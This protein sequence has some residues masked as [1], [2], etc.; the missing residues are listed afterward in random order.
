MPNNVQSHEPCAHVTSS[1]SGEHSTRLQHGVT[2][3]RR[4]CTQRNAVNCSLHPAIPSTAHPTLLP[5]PLQPCLYHAAALLRLAGNF[6]SLANS[7]HLCSG[8]LRGPLSFLQ[9]TASAPR[10][11]S[12]T[13]PHPHHVLSVLA[14]RTPTLLPLLCVHPSLSSITTS[15]W[16]AAL[17]LCQ[18]HHISPAFGCGSCRTPYCSGAARSR[19]D[20]R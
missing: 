10:L 6:A 2:T 16:Y 1:Y 8:S 18:F 3:H 15:D 19:L 4:R 14:R 11:P 9:S 13:S 7:L 12:T 17:P 20:E 5:S